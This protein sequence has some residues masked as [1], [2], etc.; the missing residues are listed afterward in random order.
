MGAVRVT[1]VLAQGPGR[2]DGDL[3]DR[4]ILHVI[5]SAGAH[6]DAA[7]W[8]AGDQPW[9]TRRERSGHPVRSGELVKIDEGWAL[10][11][12][13]SEDEPLYGLA[14]GTVRPGDVASVA[15]LDG[16]KMLSRIV[17]VDPD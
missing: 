3:D 12:L 16:D 8:S 4:M 11:E 5:L 9:R 1:M 6:L 10:R 7:E 17:A 15:R 13:G 2:P 14:A